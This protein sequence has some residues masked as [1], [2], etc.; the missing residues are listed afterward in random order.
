[1]IAEFG[2]LSLALAACLALGAG[3]S[4]LLC[5]LPAMRG[6]RDAAVSMAV[7]RSA[8]GLAGVSAAG[9]HAVLSATL[10]SRL[11]IAVP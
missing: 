7:P 5:H 4:G 8:T 3:V 2:Q 6:L 1:M 11:S 10:S 9:S